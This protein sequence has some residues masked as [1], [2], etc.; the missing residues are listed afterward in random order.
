MK[1]PKNSLN[2]RPSSTRTHANRREVAD[3]IAYFPNLRVGIVGDLMLDRF[4]F[5]TVE[6]I[7][8]EAPVP[9]VAEQEALVMPGGAGNVALNVTAL[10]AHA[11]VFGVV[12]EDVSGTELTKRMRVNGIDTYGVVTCSD[13]PTT[14]KL[15]IATYAQ[16][17]VRVDTEV[18]DAIT[19]H[20][21]TLLLQAVTAA[22]KTLDVLI[23]A[24]YDKGVVSPKVARAVVNLACTHNVPLVVDSKKTDVSCFRWARIITPNEHEARGM[25]GEGSVEAAGAQLAATLRTAVLVT[26]GSQ[27]MTLFDAD[28]VVHFKANTR[29]V[30]DVSGAGDTVVAVLAL[31]LA[32]GASLAEAVQL[33][34]AGAG[35]VVEKRG[36]ATLADH[37]LHHAAR[38][39]A[40]LLHGALHERVVTQEELL[41]LVSD[42]QAAGKRVVMTN[43]CFDLVHPGHVTYLA[44][45]R[46]LGD[47]LV[48]AVNDDAS[49]ERLKG[50]GRPVN[51]LAHRMMVLA[52]LKSVD[53]VVAFGEDTPERL[54]SAVLPDI[55]VKGSD[56]TVEQIAGHQAVLAHGGEV[57][58]I[59]LEPEHSTTDIIA[60]IRN[61]Q[62]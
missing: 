21:A 46:A 62:T 12:G 50:A 18:C 32:A 23:I 49:V 3:Y 4:L 31:A 15:R 54:I 27:G 53:L 7:S 6:R 60:S 25:T 51:T 40:S 10:G 59:D 48:V 56:Y 30:Y 36:T 19:E 41:N 61:S 11:A 22:L 20:E 1:K 42:A 43:G 14:E 55:L 37:E 44:K 39:E 29:D 13:R 5:G 28:E 26:R 45:A 38:T 16:Q 24:D 8:P 34:N 9:V 52:G 33:S 58:V 17:I 47:V 35:K 2:N 57:L